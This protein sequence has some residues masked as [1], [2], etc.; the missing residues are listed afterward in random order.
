MS[1]QT[2]Y[3][4][5]NQGLLHAAVARSPSASDSAIPEVRRHEFLQRARTCSAS[6]MDEPGEATH[7]RL[8]ASHA[9]GYTLHNEIEAAPG[10]CITTPEARP[11]GRTNPV[12]GPN[13]TV[14]A[15]RRPA[16]DPTQSYAIRREL[17]EQALRT[18]AADV[19]ALS[20]ASAVRRVLSADPSV[21]ENEGPLFRM[22]PGLLPIRR[23]VRRRRLRPRTRDCAEPSTRVLA[24]GRRLR[25]MSLTDKH[26]RSTSCTR[27]HQ[28]PSPN[29]EPPTYLVAGGRRW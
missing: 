6:E 13:A 8:T 16:P 20:G 21:P 2:V 11:T 15:R 4:W 1:R 27:Y 22:Q 14:V 18:A 10:G 17:A 7:D 9:I 28:A 12:N 26:E 24:A 5:I 19:A 23:R 29:L 25:D 3:N